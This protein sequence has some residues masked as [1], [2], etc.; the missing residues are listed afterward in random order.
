MPSPTIK[1]LLLAALLATAALPALAHKASHAIPLTFTADTSGSLAPTRLQ[2]DWTAD[3]LKISGR[4]EKQH[5]R[6]GRI[7]GH[8]ELELLDAEGQVLGRHTG[9]MH[10]FSPSRRNPDFAAF[11]ATIEQVPDSVTTVRVY[12]QIGTR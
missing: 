4:I 1:R 9:S 8:V 3:G 6:R 2:H 7:L 5:I 10:H 11:T 12:H